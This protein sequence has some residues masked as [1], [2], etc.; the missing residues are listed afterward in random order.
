MPLAAGMG[1]TVEAAATVTTAANG[2][3]GGMFTSCFYFF[4]YFTSVFE[5]GYDVLDAAVEAV[6]ERTA[7]KVAA[8]EQEAGSRRHN[9][10]GGGDSSNGEGGETVA[11]AALKEVERDGASDT[12]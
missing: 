9:G 2:D 6:E 3:G 4:I 7:I 12:P 11:D 10:R 8:H 1:E 5:G